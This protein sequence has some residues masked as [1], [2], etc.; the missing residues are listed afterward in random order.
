MPAIFARGRPGHVRHLD[1]GTGAIELHAGIERREE[2]RTEVEL[3]AELFRRVLVSE[4]R[5]LRLGGH[6]LRDGSERTG[7]I[8]RREGVGDD[9]GSGI[10]V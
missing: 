8:F 5:Q 10:E 2:F 4:G 6:I 1:D 9:H 7:K 3:L